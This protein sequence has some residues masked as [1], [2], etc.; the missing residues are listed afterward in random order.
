MNP[1]FNVV[2]PAAK[3]GII[4]PTIIVDT[5][6][7][8]PLEFRRLPSVRAGLQSGDYSYAGG[9]NL[10]AVERKSLGDLV[11]CCVGDNRTRFEREMHRLRGFHFKR[12]LVIG[13][14]DELMKGTYRSR[15]NPASVMASLK[16]W[17][18]RYDLPV[19]FAP[20]AQLAAELVESWIAWHAR[21]VLSRASEITSAVVEDMETAA[22]STEEK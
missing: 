18:V 14:L 16:A 17:E 5:R 22:V 2:L 21:D 10:F 8:Q 6:E 20:T 15:I 1:A 11:S 13:H 9:A 4:A 12:L 19:V 3:P 7:Q